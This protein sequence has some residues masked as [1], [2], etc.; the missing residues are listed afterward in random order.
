MAHKSQLNMFVFWT[1]L[2]KKG[3]QRLEIVKYLHP[4]DL[5]NPWIPRPALDL[6]LRGRASDLTLFSSVD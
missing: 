5:L 1:S 4:C 6:V 3:E 2:H